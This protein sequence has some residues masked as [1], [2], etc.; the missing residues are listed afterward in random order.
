MTDKNQIQAI[1]ILY[2]VII[3]ITSFITGKPIDDNWFRWIAGA[4]SAVV[5]VYT[6]YEK[7]IWR[8]S[9]FR[10]ISEMSGTPILH[11]TWK[12]VLQFEC[13]ASNN[14]GEVEI[15]TSIDQTLTTISIRSFFKKPS[16][17]YSVIGKIEKL[18]ANRKQ[19]IFLYKNEAPYGKRKD[20]RPHDGACV[21]NI[22]GVPVRELSGSYFT[23]RNG[24]GVIK[25]DKHNLH[26]V[27]TFEDAKKLDGF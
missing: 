21:L 6:V 11:G 8:I 20:N 5:I 23:E 10:K 16:Q 27:E 4:T 14:K 22:I 25:L 12:G 18:Q 13:D 1:I 3:F 7:W 15:F 9:V 2:S 17:S 19:L 26:L 24:S